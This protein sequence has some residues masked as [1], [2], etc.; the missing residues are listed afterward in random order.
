MKE[1]VARLSV[2]D[3]TAIAAYLASRRP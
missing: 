2:E 3:M 1:N